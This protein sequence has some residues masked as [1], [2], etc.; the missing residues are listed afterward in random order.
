MFEAL[1]KIFER[2]SR[3]LH[4]SVADPVVV[5]KF[6]DIR[7]V[8]T[9]IDPKNNNVASEITISANMASSEEGRNVTYKVTAPSK[10]KSKREMIIEGL[11]IIKRQKSVV[12]K[13]SETTETI[14][15]NGVEMKPPIFGDSEKS[16][17]WVDPLIKHW[18]GAYRKD[19]LICWDVEGFHY[20]YD[21]Y[22][23]KLARTKL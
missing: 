4:P 13:I 7:R 23:H 22:E 1:E 21:I 8:L 17:A 14:E 20:E 2:E 6:D 19:L 12:N 9:E 15:V 10:S 16:R 11:D 18:M 5:R 3:K